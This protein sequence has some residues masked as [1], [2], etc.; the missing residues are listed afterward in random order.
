MGIL[1]FIDGER[2][3]T[4]IWKWVMAETGTDISLDVVIK[5]L[6]FLKTIDWID[7]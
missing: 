6:E 1:N 7:Y 2:S 5:Y 4:K 3:I